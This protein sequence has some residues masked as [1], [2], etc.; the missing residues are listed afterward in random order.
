MSGEELRASSIKKGTP[1]THFF[2]ELLEIII[3]AI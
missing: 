3:G 2:C 1:L